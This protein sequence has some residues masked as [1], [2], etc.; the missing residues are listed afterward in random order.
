MLRNSTGI[1]TAGA[2]EK[3][4]SSINNLETQG[5]QQLVP[6]EKANSTKP[7][8]ARKKAKVHANNNRF[9]SKGSV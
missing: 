8:L 9:K 7:H 4:K 5:C 1:I 6:S 2:L 3:F